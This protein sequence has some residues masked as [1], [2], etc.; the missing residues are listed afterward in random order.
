MPRHTTLA[1]TH[2]RACTVACATD[3]EASVHA[4]NFSFVGV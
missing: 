3:A 2:S 1:G 4:Y